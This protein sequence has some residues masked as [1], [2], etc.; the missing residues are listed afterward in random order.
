MCG[1]EQEEDTSQNSSKKKKKRKKKKKS[2]QPTVEEIKQQSTDNDPVL[3]AAQEAMNCAADDPNDPNNLNKPS[4]AR[5]LPAQRPNIGFI[6]ETLAQRYEREH[7]RGPH[8]V[9]GFRAL[10]KG[11]R[12][13]QDFLPNINLARSNIEKCTT[14][15]KHLELQMVKE[16]QKQQFRTTAQDGAL[17]LLHKELCEIQAEKAAPEKEVE[18][19]IKIENKPPVPPRHPFEAVL[20]GMCGDFVPQ[21][22]SWHLPQQGGRMRDI[23]SSSRP[24]RDQYAEEDRGKPEPEQGRSRTPSPRGHSRQRRDSS[25]DIY[26]PQY[27]ADRPCPPSPRAPSP[28]GT[29]YDDVASYHSSDSD[30]GGSTRYGG[31]G[32]WGFNEGQCMCRDCMEDKFGDIFK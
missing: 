8:R 2:K 4:A 18:P 20:Q 28:T 17:R 32:W 21:N 14:K 29:V 27:D 11:K 30:R 6:E 1:E 23:R 15:L 5:R 10:A 22:R 9:F 19:E 24:T 13:V 7:R 25:P 3:V 16:L 12:W 26:Q 31:G